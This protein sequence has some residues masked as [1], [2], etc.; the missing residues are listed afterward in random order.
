MLMMSAKDFKP[1]KIADKEEERAA[2]K[3]LYNG[4]DNHTSWFAIG[5]SSL[6]LLGMFGGRM[7]RGLQPVI[8][9]ASSS[10]MAPAPDSS[11][12]TMEMETNKAYLSQGLSK[13]NSGGG[14]TGQPSSQKSRAIVVRGESIDADAIARA[15]AGK[16]LQADV[17]D[18][19]GLDA[20][21]SSGGI[22]AVFAGRYDMSAGLDTVD[23]DV[24][25]YEVSVDKFKLHRG[26]GPKW[27]AL[28]DLD[29]EQNYDLNGWNFVTPE[30]PTDWG[31]P[32]PLETAPYECSIDDIEAAK[33]LVH[34]H[35]VV[36]I[37]DAVK[38]SVLDKCA[39]AMET[40]W[41]ECDD[42][43]LAKRPPLR[44]NA[45][46]QFEFNEI[47]HRSE[48]RYDMK[49]PESVRSALEDAPWLPVIDALLGPDHV[50]LYE[51]A[52]VSVVSAKYQGQHSDNGHL[53]PGSDQHIENPHCV[54]V[55]CPLV[56]V[57][58]ENGP[59]EFWPGS[60]RESE[61]R[62]LCEEAAVMNIPSQSTLQLAGSIGDIIIFDTRTVH[63]G[64]ANESNAKRPILYLA[65]AR[66]WYTE[67]T[68][69]FP[70]ECLLGSPSE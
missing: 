33:D 29:Q 15:L 37:K 21:L 18:L 5:V 43:L 58:P 30:E 22:A 26:D 53:F 68:K 47:V 14:S 17:S 61:A 19:E 20:A 69:N 13:Q 28:G 45:S 16:G 59:T 48:G 25:R 65:Y 52:I 38:R 46:D 11:N 4:N 50:A 8:A 6:A 51:S 24:Y 34:E 63:R 41:R 57:T 27:V 23:G 1:P 31:C 62:E 12:D 35:G 70:D 60:N 10:T 9:L 44:F 2:Q 64:M 32:P 56:D 40:R 66:P 36:F 55:V 7:R 49:L 67:G 54:T 3:L 42:A 39:A